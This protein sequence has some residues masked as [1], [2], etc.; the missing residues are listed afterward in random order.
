[1]LLYNIN[2]I[3]SGRYFCKQCGYIQY[4]ANS[5]L[6]LLLLLLNFITDSLLHTCAG[7][8]DSCPYK[9]NSPTVLDK[10][11]RSKDYVTVHVNVSLTITPYESVEKPY[12]YIAILLFIIDMLKLLTLSLLFHD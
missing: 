12:K 2:T 7:K 10:F 4:M 8:Y 6:L 5:I 9:Y 11:D 1:M 3:Y